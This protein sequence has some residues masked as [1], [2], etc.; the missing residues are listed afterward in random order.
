[1]NL[2]KKLEDIVIE[3]GIPPWAVGTAGS[4]LATAS[5]LGF[6]EL[7][8][9][10]RLS[11]PEE[12]YLG[13][14]AGSTFFLVN[15]H[16]GRKY[17]M[18]EFGIRGDSKIPRQ[19]L[20]WPWLPWD[21]I[22]LHS[23]ISGPATATALVLGKEVLDSPGNL[24]NLPE[25]LETYSNYFNARLAQDAET[26]LLTLAADLAFRSTA[27]G[28]GLHYALRTLSRVATSDALK[29]TKKRS[30][31]LL[32]KGEE[33]LKRSQEF[34]ET[35]PSKLTAFQHADECLKQGDINS[36]AYYVKEVRN[37]PFEPVFANASSEDFFFMAFEDLY[38]R[39]KRKRELSLGLVL[40]SLVHEFGDKGKISELMNEVAENA[41]S[42]EAYALLGWWADEVL[43]MHERSKDYWKASFLKMLNSPEHRK[44]MLGDDLKGINN[45]YRIGPDFI[46][47]DAILKEQDPVQARYEGSMLKFV[48]ENVLRDKRHAVPKEMS[49]FDYDSKSVL[50]MT[51]HSG[52][53]LFQKILGDEA[54]FDDLVKIT[55]YLADLHSGIPLDM[56][57]I[58]NVDLKRKI[59]DAAQ[60]PFFGMSEDL[61]D[62]LLKNSEF[63]IDGIKYSERVVSQDAHGGQWIFTPDYLVKVDHNDNGIDSLFRDLAK[64]DSHPLMKSLLFEEELF[65]PLQ[66]ETYDV[67][68]TAG[69]GNENETDFRLSHLQTMLLQALSFSSA[70]S[71]EE[72]SHARNLRAPVLENAAENVMDALRQDHPEH[73]KNHKQEY[74]SVEEVF[75]EHASVLQ[76]H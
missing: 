60:N 14:I 64:R 17:S 28:V 24:F 7:G 38:G 71:N 26:Y 31:T 45:V 37:L 5:A 2:F 36:A 9:R 15:R 39:W 44:E 49:C 61:Q 48:E 10:E 63:I 40:V 68:K 23:K 34:F 30:K 47:E 55:E 33:R 74:K 69:L 75:Q 57:R 16:F 18:K 12:I 3:N 43:G 51:Y 25:S 21:S 62:R 72:Q 1:M 35:Y 58:G 54:S 56:S 67:Y 65:Y 6:L 20:K 41:N 32:S 70:W 29:K 46:K 13:L 66:K 22:F 76:A 59:K 73:Y 53:T 19:K 4:A 27:L 11:M 50:V 8:Y 42:A 52:K